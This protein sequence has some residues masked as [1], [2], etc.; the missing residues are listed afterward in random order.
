L[1]LRNYDEWIALS[2]LIV[3]HAHVALAVFYA[4]FASKAQRLHDTTLAAG[5]SRGEWSIYGW[6]VLISAIPGVV[7]MGL[8]PILTAVTALFFHPFLYRGMTRTILEERA[9]LA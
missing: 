3:G 2:L 5:R 6:V 8:P 1:G 9:A 7:C 4:R